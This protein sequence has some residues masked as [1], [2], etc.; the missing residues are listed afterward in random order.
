MRQ[1]TDDP[2]LS[3]CFMTATDGFEEQPNG[4]SFRAV[5]IVIIM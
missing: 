1:M 4:Y 5:S 2:N 3:T